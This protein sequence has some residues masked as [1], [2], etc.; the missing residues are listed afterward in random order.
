MK[1]TDNR[2]I[3]GVSP[4]WLKTYR[5]CPRR[6]QYMQQPD[7]APLN[8]GRVKEDANKK[9]SQ[10]IHV[11]IQTGSIDAAVREYRKLVGGRYN[12]F[13]DYTEIIRFVL[14]RYFR[15]NDLPQFDQWAQNGT[16]TLETEADLG[17]CGRADIVVTDTRTK[18]AQIF[19]VKFC[20]RPPEDSTQLVIYK[21]ALERQRGV[22]VVNISFIWI[23]SLIIDDSMISRMSTPRKAHEAWTEN[24]LFR[25]RNEAHE[26][27]VIPAMD[28]PHPLYDWGVEQ[29]DLS[30]S[31][32]TENTR[33]CASCP[34]RGL[35]N[36]EENPLTL[37]PINEELRENKK[38]TFSA[39][40]YGEPQEVS[41]FT[42]WAIVHSAR[43]PY[44]PRLAKLARETSGGGSEITSEP[45]EPEL[46]PLRYYHSIEDCANNTSNKEGKTLV[47][48]ARHETKS[49]DEMERLARKIVYESKAAYV[50]FLAGLKQESR[51]LINMDKFIK[52]GGMEYAGQEIYSTRPYMM[53][54]RY[55]CSMAD[56]TIMLMPGYRMA[57]GGPDN[58]TLGKCDE[59]RW[60]IENGAYRGAKTG[61]YKDVLE[62]VQKRKNDKYQKVSKM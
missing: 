52:Y 34:Y 49:G 20:T 17:E 45:L 15:N 11:G 41:E 53:S 43:L 8:R 28:M 14:T 6:A 37:E 39:V 12:A 10:A 56:A 16:I 22:E 30:S 32:K 57:Y 27:M 42:V 46:P 51:R 31:E 4:S 29:G 62:L 21:K 36:G 25:Y 48:D 33:L 2:T 58:T 60:A 9:V 7:L 1:E 40:V 13:F 19:D 5:G 44:L 38:K 61:S 50:F 24:A 3:D 59:Y 26:A 18:R 35:C 54:F 55:T 23:P 47:I